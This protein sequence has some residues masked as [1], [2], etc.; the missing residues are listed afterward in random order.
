MS[1][2][3]SDDRAT[4]PDAGTPL[5]GRLRGMLAEY[6]ILSRMLYS[7]AGIAIL[8]ALWWLGGYLLAANPDTAYFS[9]LSPGPTAVEL[10]GL[11]QSFALYEAIWAS[12][13]RLGLGLIWAIGLGVPIGVAVGYFR[14]AREMAHV[15]FQFLRM[16]SPLSWMPIAV[17]VFPSWE[18][19]IV[20]LIL[21]AAVWPIVFSTAYGV[22]R[23]DPLW[24]KVGRNM[25]AGHLQ[26]LRRIIMPAIAADIFSGIRLALGVAW[27]V[28]VPAEYLGVTSGLGYMIADARD[29]MSYATLSSMVV[30]IGVIGF[31][32]DAVWLALI[33]RFSWQ[34]AS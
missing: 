29:T 27:I 34:P 13:Y 21:M 28:L 11:V 9:A 8:L 30:V 17:L 33:K 4:A 5:M 10:W 12:L 3:M 2:V 6:A 32:L 7:A 1:T 15:P 16:I 20:F 22:Q 18:Q 23:I 19:A 26:T 24:L 31:L 14:P 25:G